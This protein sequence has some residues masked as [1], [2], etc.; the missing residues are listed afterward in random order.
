VTVIPDD[1]TGSA[2][3]WQTAAAVLSF[4]RWT[5]LLPEAWTCPSFTIGMPLRTQ[6]AAITASYAASVSAAV[7]NVAMGQIMHPPGGVDPAPG[8]ACS[9]LKPTMQQIFNTVY[10]TLGAKLTTP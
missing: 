8:V 6:N 7:A 5:G 3:G 1:G 2:G 9:Q 4:K 10:G